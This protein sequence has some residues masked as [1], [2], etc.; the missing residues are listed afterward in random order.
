[1]AFWNAPI[2]YD[3]HAELACEAA[4]LQRK[5]LEKVRTAI[6]ELGSDVSVDMRIG[7][8]TGKAVIGNF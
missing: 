5:A 2:R 3:N 1:M 8:N 4:I 6:R 7:I